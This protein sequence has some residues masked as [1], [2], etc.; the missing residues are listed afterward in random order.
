MAGAWGWWLVA[1]GWLVLEDVCWLA[2]GW[3]VV[4]GG[5]LEVGFSWLVASGLREVGG[6]R[7]AGGVR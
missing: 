2:R 4:P 3:L 5:W 1:G 7:L 6:W